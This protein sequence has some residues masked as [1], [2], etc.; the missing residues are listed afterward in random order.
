MTYD[1]E[2]N[3]MCLEISKGD[4]SHVREFGNF[5][6][7]VSKTE[8]PIILEILDASKFV[9]QVEKIRSLKEAKSIEK[10]VPAN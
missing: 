8:K 6:L 3:I 1:P 5:I 4:I 10:T 2:A 9:G 7:H